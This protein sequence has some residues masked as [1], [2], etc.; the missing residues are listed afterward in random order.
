M[1]QAACHAVGIDPLA[2]AIVRRWIAHFAAVVPAVPFAAD[3]ALAALAAAQ[4]APPPAVAAAAA[5][6][7]LAA[8]A[9][10]AALMAMAAAALVAVAA[11]LKAAAAAA[12]EARADPDTATAPAHASCGV[13]QQAGLNRKSSA[14]DVHPENATEPDRQPGRQ[15]YYHDRCGTLSQAIQSC[16]PFDRSRP[17]ASRS[18]GGELRA[19]LLLQIALSHPFYSTVLPLAS[20]AQRGL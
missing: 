13:L 18:Q 10:A 2:V 1:A 8:V 5:Q 19:K 11:A 4:A 20:T 6:A 16:R 9:A 12:V 15:L 3:A 17:R 14:P 7:A